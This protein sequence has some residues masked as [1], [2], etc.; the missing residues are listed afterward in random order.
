MPP[1]NGAGFSLKDHLFNKRKVQYLADLFRAA[2]ADFDAKSFV[3]QATRPFKSLELKERIAHLAVTLEDFL[4]DDFRVSAKQIMEALPPPL[5]PRKTDDDFGDFILAPLGEYVVRNGL[6]KRHL[7]LSLRTL[8]EITQRFSMEDAIRHFINAFPDETLRE[9]EKW[10][11]DSNY[12]VR[13]LVSEGARPTLPWSGRL[14]VDFTQPLPLLDKLHADPTRYVTRS[15]A[16]HLNDISK[17]EPT[18]AI[19]TLKRWKQE[20]VQQQDEFNWI[21]KHALRTLIKQG[22]HDAL[23]FLGFR[24][25]PKIDIENFTVA[26]KRLKPGEVLEFAFDIVAERDE[27]LI[28]DY[29]IDFVKANG[30]L[31][32]KVHKLKQLTEKNGKRVTLKKQHTLRANATTYTLYPGTHRVTIQINGSAYG[33]LEF[34]LI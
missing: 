10:S 1:K 31:A 24:T 23:K 32:P 34:E 17:L 3:K 2:D 30:S 6:S 12:H 9:L 19:S 16:N 33:T 5:D 14:A 15:V 20:S 8:K 26:R 7:K 29:V 22:H 21:A 27:P 25:N 11:T 28:V 13:R 18:H 4:N